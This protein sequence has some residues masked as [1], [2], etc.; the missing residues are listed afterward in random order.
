MNIVKNFVPDGNIIVLNSIPKFLPPREKSSVHGFI[1]H[2]RCEGACFHVVHYDNL[3]V[4]CSEE[5][6]IINATSPKRI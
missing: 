3:G 1:K 5:K 2:V 4:H 6:C